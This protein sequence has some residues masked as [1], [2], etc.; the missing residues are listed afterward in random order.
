MAITELV[1]VYDADGGLLGE[2]A[3]V[4]GKLRGTKHCGL[5]DITHSTVRRKGEWDRMAASLPVPVRLLHLNELDDELRASVAA[6]GAPVVLG[7]DGSGWRE[8]VGAAELDAMGGSVGALE[9]VLRRQLE[10]ST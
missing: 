2:A 7:R 8:L 4:W 1:G 9:V 6:T 5:C 3:Y 10:A